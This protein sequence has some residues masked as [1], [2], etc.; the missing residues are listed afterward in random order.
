MHRQRMFCLLCWVVACSLAA[1]AM[2]RPA[3][4]QERPGSAAGGTVETIPADVVIGTLA[5]VPPKVELTNRFDYRQILVTAKTAAGETVDVTRLVQTAQKPKFVNVTAQGLVTAVADGQEEL[6]LNYAGQAVRVAVQV[7]GV[8][9]DY[10]VSFVRDVQPVLSKTGCNQGTCHGAKE[11]KNGFK[12]SLRGYDP[13]YD[14]RALTDDIGA[15]RINRAAPDQSLMLL[16]ATGSIPHVGGVRLNVGDAY[17][18]ILRQWIADGMKLDLDAVR[19]AKVEV[20]PRDPIIPRAGMKQQMMVLATYADGNVRDVTREAFIES[21]NIEVIEAN[22]SGVLTMLRRGEAPVLVRYE[23]AYAAT[24]IIVMGD[25]SGFAWNDPPTQSPIDELVYR[26]LQRVKILPSDLCGDEEFLRRVY[27]DLTGLPPTVETV[28]A[29]LADGRETRVKRDEL[30]DRLVGSPAFVEQWTNKWADLL[31]VNRK[32]LGEEGSVMLR[33]WIKNAL[34]TNM[35]YD[36]FARE[37]LTASGSNVE[38][39]PAA[40]F[41]VLRQPQDLMENTTHLFLAIRFN[42]NKCHDHPFERWTQDQY[43]QMSAFFSQ[44]GRKEDPL[45]AGQRIGGSAVE[46]AA[47]LVEVVYDTGGGEVKHDRTGQ[48][49]APAVPYQ[50]EINAQATGSRRAQ[51]AHWITAKE[52]Q[53][54]ARSYVNRVWGYLFGRGIIEPIDDIRAGNPPTNPELLDWL[55]KEFVDHGFDTQHVFKVICKSRV[56]QHSVKANRWNEDDDINNSHALPRRLPAEVLFD[57]IHVATG[58]TPRIQ[59]APTGF[60]AAELPDAGVSEP[61]LEDFGRPVRESACE[62]ERSS[63]MVLGPV[64]KLINGPTVA[65]AIASPNNALAQLVAQQADDRV[66]IEEMFLRFLAR[67]PAPAEIELGLKA[68]QEA[69]NDHEKLLEELRAYEAKL[70]ERQVAWEKTAGQPTVWT[71][72]VPQEF[73]SQAGATIAKKEDH[74]LLVSGTLAKD[75]YTVVA[76]TDLAGITGIRLEALTDPALPSNG[77]GRADNGNFVLH[78]LKM[79]VAPKSNPGKQE[80]VMLRGAN[81]TFSQDSL[82]VSAAVDGN[83]GTGWAIFPQ[84]GKN[85]TATFETGSPLQ[86]EGGALLTF[87]LNQQF[88]DGKHL[89]GRFRLSVTNSTAPFEK[90]ALPPEVTAALAVAAGERTAAHK[91]TLTNYFRSLDVGYRERTEAIARSAEQQKNRRLLGVQ[92]LAWALINNPAFLFNR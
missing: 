27:L 55:T 10:P 43:Y 11:G 87:T 82:P 72:L 13:I 5:V 38:N 47:P 32:F 51:L 39:P 6:V 63:G 1:I 28:K 46:G 25:R 26:K 35:P 19:V 8:A 69:G 84:A 83:D 40:Y 12:L 66:V 90:G 54:F 60:R 45:F 7:S 64:M 48:V 9:A 36:Q 91:Q 85:Q 57:A 53:Y 4:S 76:P 75:L 80:P 77:P 50:R 17:Y 16:K 81:A 33:N 20:L 22:Q 24:T 78:E 31:Q 15:R 58:A 49:T 56:Y 18:E 65:D 21:G 2:V 86:I 14:H 71:P 23:G 52:N 89:L 29:F 88:P 59:G 73:K 79:T 30:I 68:I 42:C 34:A 70:V 41:K 3:A 44:V 61:F 67:R 62:C 74:S 92:D 37:I